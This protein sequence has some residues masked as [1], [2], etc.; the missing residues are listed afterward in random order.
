MTAPF[1]TITQSAAN[2]LMRMARARSE[3][4]D[5]ID[6]PAEPALRKEVLAQNSDYL[7]LFA[8]VPA[9]EGARIKGNLYHLDRAATAG[10]IDAARRAYDSAEAAGLFGIFN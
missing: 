4:I 9:G 1:E 3:W 8:G 7:D 2:I 6:T 5:G 10:D